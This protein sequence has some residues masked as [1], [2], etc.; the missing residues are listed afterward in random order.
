MNKC[1]IESFIIESEDFSEIALLSNFIDTLLLESNTYSLVK[2]YS[3]FN[4]ES[5]LFEVLDYVYLKD[6][7][8]FNLSKIY[9]KKQIDK[10]QL[11][12]KHVFITKTL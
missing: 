6:S 8:N 2:D 12:S 5:K 11:K 9:S 1:F 3:G 10:Y 7:K 4:A